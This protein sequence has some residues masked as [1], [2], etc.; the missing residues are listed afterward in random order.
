M[1]P[2]AITAM[3]W[4]DGAD[5]ADSNGWPVEGEFNPVPMLVPSDLA[6]LT[7]V[8]T[9]M[10]DD[11]AGSL[12]QKVAVYLEGSDPSGYAIQDGGSAE[13]GEQLFVYQLA[14]DGAPELA[15]DAFA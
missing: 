2:N 6:A 8:Y 11:T 7:G 12:G 4:K 15:P 5:D 13:E 14:V 3:G 1:L 9:L 10:M